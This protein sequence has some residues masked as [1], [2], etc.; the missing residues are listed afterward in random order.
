MGWRIDKTYSLERVNNDGNYCP[1]NC[2]WI[3]KSEQSKNSRR[4]NLIEYKNKKYCLTDLCKLLNLPYSTMRHRVNDLKI[5]FLEAIKYPQNY[6]FK[7]IITEDDYLSV[8]NKTF[9]LNK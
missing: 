2:K 6:K 3:L 5:P 4:V 1:E 7:K 9:F 8:V